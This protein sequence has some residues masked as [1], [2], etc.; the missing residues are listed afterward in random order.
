MLSDG[1]LVEMLDAAR[2]AG[3]FVLLESF[4]GDDLARGAT[5]GGTADCAVLLG[6]NSRDLAT[7]E[8]DPLRL[9]ALA[10]SFPDDAIRVAES[11]IVNAQDAVNAA[12]LGYRVG[13][14]GTALMRAA[15]PGALLHAIL[16]A[17]RG[18]LMERGGET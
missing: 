18:A 16:L 14:I 2:E 7:L 5:L 10:F 1:Q 13:L 12:R 4:D 8:V 15:D 6:V 9:A 11:G 3:V 17:A